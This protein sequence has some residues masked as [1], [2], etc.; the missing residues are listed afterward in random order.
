MNETD[1]KMVQCNVMS[2]LRVIVSN[3]ENRRGTYSIELEVNINKLENN[4]EVYSL[5]RKQSGKCLK[6]SET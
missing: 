4:G 6:A 1:K 3:W 2:K 5:Y